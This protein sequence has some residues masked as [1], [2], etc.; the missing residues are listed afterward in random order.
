MKLPVA[1]AFCFAVYGSLGSNPVRAT[2]YTAASCSASDVSAK[3]ALATDGDTVLVPGSTCGSGAPATW[4]T[5]VTLNKGIT[6]NG[7]GAYVQWSSPGQ[8][9][10]NADTTANTFVTGFTFLGGYA[11]GACPITL[12]S[13]YSP[14]SLTYRF[15]HNSLTNNTG[16]GAVQLCADGQGPGLIDHNT[17]QGNQGGEPVQNHGAF[18]S[19]NDNPTWTSDVVPGGPNMT[20]FEDNTFV[21]ND[22]AHEIG[23][24]NDYYGMRV[25]FRHN[26]VT[27]GLVDAHGGGPGT[28]TRWVEV[29]Q[30]TFHVNDPAHC[31]SSLADIR[32]G[33]GMFWGNHASSLG[34]A[35]SGI[36]GANFGP[37]CPSSDPCSGTW[38]LPWQG[39][40]G[41][42][43]G[44]SEQWSPFYDWGNDA[45]LGSLGVRNAPYIQVGATPTSC[46][47]AGNVCDGVDYGSGASTP[48]NLLR[49]QSAADLVAGCPVSYT[50]TPYTY[51]HPLQGGSAS[52]SP[53]TNLTAVVQ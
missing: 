21:N 43:N 47:H 19:T 28:G 44:T 12:N 48:P 52:T 8:L 34:G 15:H 37:F 7:Q 4:S 11:P 49:C 24:I 2:T 16:P 25:V 10:V 35:C 14:R 32:G 38:P 45:N 26:D 39:G 17:I 33:S 41:I 23:V 5:T 31:Q 20:F 27:R 30:N 9:V 18:A 51:P 13:T 1:L 36:P 6:L 3:V 42:N 53:P 22:T 40:R 29:Y 50:Y 46:S